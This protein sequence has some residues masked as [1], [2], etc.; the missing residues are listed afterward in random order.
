MTHVEN[1][2]CAACA[3]A[4]V[5]YSPWV[6]YFICFFSSRRRHTR[7]YG[8]WSSDVCSSD[9]ISRTITMIPSRIGRVEPSALDTAAGEIGRASCRGRVEISVGAV[10]FKK[11]THDVLDLG[12]GEVSGSHFCA[13]LRESDAR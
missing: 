3:L 9:L 8:D 11:N 6:N 5:C 2:T 12:A 4:L 13:S 10:S 7:S 1:N